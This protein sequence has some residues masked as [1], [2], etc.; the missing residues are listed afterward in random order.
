MY[1]SSNLI[2][3]CFVLHTLIT[4]SEFEFWTKLIQ[5][6]VK[7]RAFADKN[8]LACAFSMRNWGILVF[9]YFKFF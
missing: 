7:L 8:S 6:L 1:D 3:S 5:F 2:F 9:C 4:D